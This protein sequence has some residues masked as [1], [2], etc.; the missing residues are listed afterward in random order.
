MTR[1]PYDIPKA[2]VWEA[3]LH[4]KA[5]RGAAGIDAE[6]IERFEDKLGDNLYKVWNR[7]SSGS[8][9]PPAVKAVPIPNVF[10]MCKQ[11]GSYPRKSA[12]R[13]RL[14]PKGFRYRGICSY[15]LSARGPLASP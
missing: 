11:H 8:Y 3:W 12:I 7:M 9:L 14:F 10:R 4:V 13:G 2:L 15:L 5:N 1:K 6:T